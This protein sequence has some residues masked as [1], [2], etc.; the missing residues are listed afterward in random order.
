MINDFIDEIKQMKL[1]L[2]EDSCEKKDPFI[3]LGLKLEI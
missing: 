2:S 3:K 1:Q